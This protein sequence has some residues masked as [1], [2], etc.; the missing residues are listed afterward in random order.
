MYASMREILVYVCDVSMYYIA[1]VLVLVLVLVFELK[2]VLFLRI[3]SATVSVS[4]CILCDKLFTW[5]ENIHH[6]HS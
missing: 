4:P 2:V 1:L 5:L 6:A 3:E